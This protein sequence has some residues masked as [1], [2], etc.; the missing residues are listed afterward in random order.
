MEAFPHT[1]VTMV[2]MHT[3]APQLIV[4]VQVVEPPVDTTVTAAGQTDIIATYLS[5]L[6]A[7]QAVALVH[8]AMF[9]PVQVSVPSPN[10]PPH[11]LPQRLDHPGHLCFPFIAR[12]VLLAMLKG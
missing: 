5:H 1:I 7:A 2:V 12:K 10:N 6:M 4:I 11:N 9:A 8:Q 3:T